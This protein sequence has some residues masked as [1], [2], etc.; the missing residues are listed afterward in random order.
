MAYCVDPPG[1][2]NDLQ[3]VTQVAHAS[4]V[5]WGMSPVVG[6]LNYAH[7]DGAAFQKP[8]SEATAK[9]IDDEVKRIADE[10]FQDAR[11]LLKEHRNKLDDLARALLDH[12]SLDEK[13][14]LAAT[15]P[16]PP[17]KTPHGTHR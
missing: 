3:P 10:C 1:A 6:P 15:G 12:D 5:R 2:V 8:Y 7:D 17:R 4:V 9:L 11:R 16:T 13:A 14:L